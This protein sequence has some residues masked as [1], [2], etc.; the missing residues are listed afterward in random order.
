MRGISRRLFQ[1]FALTFAAIIFLQ[2]SENLWAKE[3]KNKFWTYVKPVQP[4]IPK[5][6]GWG[7]NVIDFFIFQKMKG[8]G[9]SPEKEASKEE[10]LRRVTFDLTGLP[11]SI[12]EIDSF[13]NDD[14]NDAFDTVV[15]KL[16]GSSRYGE[17]MAAWWLDGARYGD[18]HG[19]DNDLENSQWP[20][21]NWV[22]E[23]FNKNKPFNVFT[24]EQLAGDLLPNPSNDQLIATGFNRN[25]R[26][27]TEGG[28][29]DEEWRTEYVIDRVETMG[30]VWMGLTLS[31]AR[32]H[33]HKYDPIT[34]REFYELFAFFN[35]LDEKG[36]INNLR[37]SADPKVRYKEQEFNHEVS[38]IRSNESEKSDQDKK[39]SEIE[40]SYPYVMVMREMPERR[41][42]F[43][44]KGGQYDSVGEEVFPDLPSSL[45]ERSNDSL[46]NRMDLAKWLVNGDHPL[47]SRVIVNRIWALFFGTGIVSSTENFGVRSSPPSNSKLL[48][49]IAVDFVEN[50]WDIKRLI[51]QITMSAAYRQKHA[52][53]SKSLKVDPDNRLISRGPRLRLESEMIRDQALFVSGLL[54][55]KIGGPSYW[56]YQP[57]GLW[58]DIE[59]RGTFKQDHGEKLYRRSLYSRIRRTVPNPSMAIFDMPSRE[60]CNVKRSSSNTPLQALSLLNSVT[61]VEAAKKLG[62]RMMQLDGDLEDKIYWG[63][64]SVTSRSPEDFEVKVLVDGYRR[65]LS[66]FESDH[67]QADALLKVGESDVLS[68][69]SSVELAAMTTVA[70]VLL[71]LDEAINK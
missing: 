66:H 35:N 3:K 22:I 7:H 14:S 32:C 16:L 9:L 40:R 25:H 30:T 63:F 15:N 46:M 27:Q 6:A 64:R 51:K 29:I 71:N 50:G 56:V 39:I 48:D 36:F 10:W 53:N 31:C 28:A 19:Y 55:D 43:I 41:K 8:V 24:I 1:L 62:E 23:S 65:R 67:S 57:V 37:G 69:L 5:N 2:S 52:V 38:K 54:V 4:I 33:D 34:Q 60:V 49:W 21:R 20:W 17:R 11:P 18:S 58:R 70:N 68:S 61:H 59:K 47:T 42:A 12:T 26:I 13:L 45:S 44:L